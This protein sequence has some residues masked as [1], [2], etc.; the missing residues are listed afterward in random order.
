MFWSVIKCNLLDTAAADEFNEWYNNEHA[1]RYIAQPGF[2]RGWRLERYDQPGQRGEA[3]QRFVAVYETESIGAFNAALERDFA[4]SHPWE[5]WE[6]KVKDWQRTYYRMIFSF[7][8]GR[9]APFDEQRFWTIV[10]IDLAGLSENDEQA[11]NDWYDRQHVPE[12]CSFAGF[13]RAWRLILE[14]D[15]GDLGP[16]GQKYMA[17]YETDDPTYLPRVRRGAVPWDGIWNE[18]I[19]NWEIVFYRKRYDYEAHARR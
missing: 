19:R 6:G 13:R 15:E 18:H 2:R 8:D 1:P 4:Q 9:S 5:R 11:F 12:V 16:R 7:G 10:R 17:I 14:P 3:G